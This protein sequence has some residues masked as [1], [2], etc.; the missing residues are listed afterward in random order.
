MIKSLSGDGGENALSNWKEKMNERKSIQ[1]KISSKIFKFLKYLKL[2]NFFFLKINF[3]SA[4]KRD[5]I[6]IGISFLIKLK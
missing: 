1:T 5:K 6:K 2:M 4:V 3:T